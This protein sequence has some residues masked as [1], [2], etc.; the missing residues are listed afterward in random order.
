[1]GC[2]PCNNK[3]TSRMEIIIIIAGLRQSGKTA[4]FF[5]LTDHPHFTNPVPTIHLNSEIIQ[6]RNKNVTLIDLPPE[7]TTPRVFNLQGII[8]VV[9]SSDKNKIEDARLLFTRLI[10]EKKV[11]VLL[12][13]SKKDKAA[14]T[15]KEV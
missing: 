4:I 3:K 7:F 10:A 2:E 13:L 6:Y 15:E 12:L 14:V 1:M 8:F 11:P 9:D 5:K